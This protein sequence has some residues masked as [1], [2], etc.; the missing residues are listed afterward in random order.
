M[1]LN[2]ILQLYETIKTN[3]SPYGIW[4]FDFA[5]I[6]KEPVIAVQLD[7]EALDLAAEYKELI[8]PGS[9]YVKVDEKKIIDL[10][11]KIANKPG[12]KKV[13]LYNLDLLLS[14]LSSEQRVVFWELLS[15]G[16]IYLKRCLVFMVPQT[17]KNLLPTGEDLD[18]WKNNQRIVFSK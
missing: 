12:K 3:R 14:Y 13:L 1:D 4:A 7:A 11:V 2:N 8:I 17:A 15:G 6:G 16:I 18:K 10:V 9:P 5:L